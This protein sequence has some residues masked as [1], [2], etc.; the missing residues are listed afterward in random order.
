MGTKAKKSGYTLVDL[1]YADILYFSSKNKLIEYLDDT[2]GSP[3]DSEIAMKI[4]VDNNV[5]IFEG[6][7]KKIDVCV[8]NSTKFS[9]G[10]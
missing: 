5:I 2:F 4:Y 3:S 8:E 10:E 1:E 6:K 7:C 9:I